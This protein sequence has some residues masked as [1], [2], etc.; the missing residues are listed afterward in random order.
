MFSQF[1]DPLNS[2]CLGYQVPMFFLKVLEPDFGDL[3][4]EGE[5]RWGVGW[6]F[7]NPFFWGGPAKMK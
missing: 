5:A 6:W 3:L 1:L 4:L 7:V 2:G